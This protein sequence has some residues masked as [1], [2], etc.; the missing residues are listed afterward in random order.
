MGDPHLRSATTVGLSRRAVLPALCLPWWTPVLPALAAAPATRRFV[1]IFANGGWD[2]TR[3]LH[4][5]FDSAGVSM[6]SGAAPASAH[7][8][9]F[10]DHPGRPVVREVFERWGDRMALVRGLLVPSVNHDV[11]TRLVS[12]GVAGAAPCWL[13]R[14]ASEGS[15][16]L[17]ALVLGGPTYPEDLVAAVVR[18]G[19][20]G[21]LQELLDGEVLDDADSPA[22]LLA[23]LGERILDSYVR[24]RVAAEAM[25]SGARAEYAAARVRAV[26]SARRLKDLRGV[27]QLGGGDP[28]DLAVRALAGGY[29]RCIGLSA[30]GDGEW[31]THSENDRDQGPLWEGLFDRLRRLLQRLETTLGPEGEPLSAST[32]LCV[33]SEMGRT[34]YLNQR[35]GKD[36]WPWTA[37]VLLGDGVRGGAIAGG[38]D[39]SGQGRPVDPLSG[40]PWDRGD[41]LS[42]ARLGATLLQLAGVDPARAG[43]EPLHTVLL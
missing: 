29:S 26:D 7:G 38:F 23:P 41:D 4:P 17:P 32:V 15:H 43:A 33:S 10:V 34:P 14:I 42:C 28:V 16:A 8:I 31:D 3:V 39:D 22:P 20:D 13:S 40:E 11:C 18:A 21:A 24:R 35:A 2:P 36:H 6:E 27:L 12:T 25:G 1:F 30:G 5:A 19:D 9:D 37:A